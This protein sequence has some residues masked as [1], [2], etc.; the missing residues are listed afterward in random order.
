MLL[1]FI[2]IV[3][4]MILLVADSAAWVEDMPR[5]EKRWVD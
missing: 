1:L 2:I 5:I 3:V 4:G